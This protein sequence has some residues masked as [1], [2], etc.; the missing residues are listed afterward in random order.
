MGYQLQNTGY[1]MEDNPC[2][3]KM[4]F[5]SEKEAEAA[6]VQAK[7]DHDNKDLVVYKCDKCDLYHLTTDRDD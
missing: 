7:W 6:K 2:A 1:G 5:L 4:S 3:D